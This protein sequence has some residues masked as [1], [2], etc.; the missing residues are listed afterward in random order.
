MPDYGHDLWF[1]VNPVP[2]SVDTASVVALAQLAERAG[3]DLVTVQDHPHQPALLDAWTLLSFLAARTDIV[4]LAG[5]V[6]PLPLRHPAVLARSA[7]SLDLLSGGRIELGLGAGG[8]VDGVTAMGG[9]P[10][11]VDTVVEAIDVVRAIVDT[12]E[13]GPARVSGTR[14]R[15]DT[16]RGPRPAHRIGIWL[17]AYGPRMLRLTGARADGW[18]PSLPRMS[19]AALADGNATVDTATRAAGRVPRDVR[20][21]LN[22]AEPPPSA[23]LADLALRHGFSAFILIATE[24]AAVE[25]FLRDTA[26]E[27]RAL[28]SAGR[29]AGRAALPR[30]PR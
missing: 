13:P 9:T 29:T 28:V 18:L 26:P 7:A 30:R 14:Y 11:T 24:P 6:H 16:A 27:V 21:L 25:R 2:A 5:N 23:R 4:R 10:S 1:G 8:Y 22:L 17:G 12:E 20:R 3:A 19:D 15:I